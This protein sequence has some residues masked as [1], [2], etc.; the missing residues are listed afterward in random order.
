MSQERP[1]DSPGDR[2]GPATSNEAASAAHEERTLVVPAVELPLAPSRPVADLSN[3]KLIRDAP[4]VRVSGL[5]VPSLGGVPLLCKL[6]QGGMGAVYYGIQPEAGREV[7][8][9]VLPFHL[10]ERNPEMQQRFH[11]EARLAATIRSPHL[12]GILDVNEENGLVFMVLEYVHGASAGAYL[13]A[14]RA[15]G[16]VLRERAALD[17]ALAAARGL[18]AAHARGIIH[19]D[20]KPD[21]LLIPW[22]AGRNRPRLDEAKLADLGLART[23]ETHGD[24]LT[25]SSAA[26]GTPG[27]M[28]PEQALD[29]KSA[30]RPADLFGL[31]ATLYA[32][33]C[34]R[35]PF[36]ATSVML[37]LL[38]TA[39]R[40]HVSVR[41]VREDVSEA[42]AALIDRC[43]AKDPAQRFP[44]AEALIA[45]LEACRGALAESAELTLKMD[46]PDLPPA[47]S[48]QEVPTRWYGRGPAPPAS[49]VL[50]P[51][52]RSRLWW[53][54]LIAG[55]VAFVLFG[56]LAFLPE[57]RP[58]PKPIRVA[59]Q[60]PPA[61]VAAPAD[62]RP[63]PGPP[64]PA[65]A[66]L[67]GETGPQDRER[68]DKAV[69][70]DTLQ[71]SAQAE[72]PA[73][74]SAPAA[75]RDLKRFGFEPPEPAT[76]AGENDRGLDAAR[77]APPKVA[78]VPPP[79]G[80]A[81][82]RPTYDAAMAEGREALAQERW[83]AAGKAFQTA[84]DLRADDAEAQQG[85]RS[86]AEGLQREERFRALVLA[87]QQALKDGDWSAAEKQLKAARELK[88]ASRELQAALERLQDERRVRPSE[89]R[90][91]EREAP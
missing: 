18:A 25:A 39:Q 40:P 55:A 69:W 1:A 36:R 15:E 86:A 21:N 54:A 34:G 74:E 22:D 49:P 37:T 57:E 89:A 83:E 16:L 52:K 14:L 81:A 88:P 50:V 7:A 26:L 75:A 91:T 28:A 11:R 19:R 47:S 8:V 73:V 2:R 72:R 17:L 63:A 3:D 62:D 20:V 67:V 45:A 53:A 10:A 4:R 90:S 51:V 60:P 68:A 71:Q 61:P 80:P 84:L 70:A 65:P 31:G 42:T 77:A 12:V 64:P 76:D 24:S 58:A 5:I 29:A 27:Y 30:G 78:S 43:L 87:A 13:K 48:T 82:P 41:Q 59:T 38:E 56:V 23:V 35:A 85:L 44:N 79:P 32:I 46:V 66:P 9:K 6:G 33:L